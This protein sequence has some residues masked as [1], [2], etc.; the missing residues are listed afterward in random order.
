MDELFS[1]HKLNE[2]GVVKAKAI[3]M[4]FSTLLSLLTSYCGGSSR[5]MSVVKTKL[6]EACFFAKRAMAQLPENQEQ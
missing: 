2:A 4:D 5:E 1:V 6:Q 3:A